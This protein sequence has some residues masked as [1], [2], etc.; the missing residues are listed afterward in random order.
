MAQLSYLSAGTGPVLVLVHGYLGA[1]VQWEREIAVFSKSFRVIA[2]DLPGFG[3]TTQCGECTTIGA[4]AQAVQGL[5]DDLGV[6]D[7][8]LLGHSMGGMIVQDLA[9][10]R[11]DG[12]R[13]LILY[14]TGPLGR[15]PGRFERL[16]TSRARLLDEGVEKTAARICATWFVQGKKAAGYPLLCRIGAQACPQ[17]A[18]AALNAMAEWDGRGA[19][20]RLNVPTLILWGDRDASY[21]WPQVE[22]LWNNLPDTRLAV[23]PG[24][25]HAVHLEKPALFDALVTD[26]LV[27]GHD[28]V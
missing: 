4:M 3:A 12:V 24:A 15:M 23:V 25:S 11:P 14:G 18:E 7:F 6:R 17:A 16:A 13:R 1:A 27:S 8:T 2:P 9:A 21:R 22:M 26:F 28:I 19:L 20:T 5:L 10:R